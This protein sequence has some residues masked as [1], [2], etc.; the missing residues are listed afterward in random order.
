LVFEI[1]ITIIVK[2]L[3]TTDEGSTKNSKINYNK[4]YNM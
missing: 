4:V 1:Y 3:H 2:L